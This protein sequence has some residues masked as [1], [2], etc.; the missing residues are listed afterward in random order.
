MTASKSRTT[1]KAA[2]AAAPVAVAHVPAAPA[3]QNPE[4]GAILNPTL[5]GQPVPGTVK[6]EPALVDTAGAATA[7]TL[8]DQLHSDQAGE[9][10]QA[11]DVAAAQLSATGQTGAPVA[12]RLPDD[13]AAAQLEAARAAE[14]PAAKVVAADTPYG[15]QAHATNGGD[16]LA[17]NAQWFCATGQMV[18]GGEPDVRQVAFYLGMQLEELAEKVTAVFGPKAAAD[19]MNALGDKLKRGT[20]DDEVHAAL[21]NPA[22]AKELLDGDIDLLWVTVGAAQAA[23]SDVYGAYGKVC[24]ANWAKRWSDG[25]FHRDPTTGKVLKP[26]GWQAPDLSSS[27]HPDL[28]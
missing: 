6:E 4:P 20:Y 12:D 26:E 28:R 13:D 10:Q 23:G 1:A 24:E 3:A 27:V 11:S 2:P 8:A 5:T 22:A 14:W 17:L 19:V 18:D 25:T 9:R 21:T 7:G 16:L 15:T